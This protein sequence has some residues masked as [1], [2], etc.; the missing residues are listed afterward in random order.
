MHNFCWFAAIDR[1]VVQMK[2]RQAPSSPE[3]CLV[4]S[5]RARFRGGTLIALDVH[6]L[7]EHER[8]LRRPDGYRPPSCP[9]CQGAR[10]HLHDHVQRIVIE[11]RQ[12]SR[13]EIVRYLCAESACRATWRVLPAFVARHLWR[14]WSTVARA[15]AGD[16]RS[17][18]DGAQV[19]IPCTKRRPRPARS[20]DAVSR[21]WTRKCDQF[22]AGC[23]SAGG[24]TVTG[25]RASSSSRSGMRRR[26][27]VQYLGASSR[28]R[29]GGQYGM[30]RMMSVR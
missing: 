24:G 13:I 11:S 14:R 17:V 12:V 30:T 21:A 18:L 22:G 1:L 15:I 27:A 8:R 2:R 7:A 28:Y 19:G 25:P 26:V 4:H 3:P 10:L 23:C 9:R 16:E 6:E 20:R 5:R 29:L